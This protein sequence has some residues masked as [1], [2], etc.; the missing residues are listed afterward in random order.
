[1]S[2]V[3]YGWLHLGGVLLLQVPARAVHTTN[4]MHRSLHWRRKVLVM[5][6]VVDAVIPE[7]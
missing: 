3:T 5:T 4:A 1:M 2:L 7:N 6:Q